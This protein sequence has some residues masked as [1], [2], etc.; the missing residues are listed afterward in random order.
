M[1]EQST[2]AMEQPQS[3]SCR[4]LR[5]LIA[6]ASDPRATVADL[7]GIR[8]HLLSLILAELARP[9]KDQNQ[10]AVQQMRYT[11]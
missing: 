6:G 2:P 8:R 11:L 3:L 10:T 5:C 7:K 4:C 1:S 9:R